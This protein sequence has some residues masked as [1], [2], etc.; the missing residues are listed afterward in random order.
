MFQT[1]KTLFAGQ[2]AR[3]EARVRNHY[4]LDL[5]DQKIRETEAGLKAAKTSLA[6]LIQRHRTETTQTKSLASRINNLMDRARTALDKGLDDLAGETA[7]ALAEMEN[8]MARRS[9]TCERLERKIASLRLK[10]EKAQ[11]RLVDRKRHG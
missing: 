7:Q 6:T 11:R 9:E 4:A 1:F 10:V 3:D 2:M 5:I 8:E